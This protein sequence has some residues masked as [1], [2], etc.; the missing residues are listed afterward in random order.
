MTRKANPAPLAG[1]GGANS[2]ERKSDSTTLAR[3]EGHS[4]RR[5]KRRD[6]RAERIEAEAPVEPKKPVVDEE[7][8]ERRVAELKSLSPIKYAVARSPTAKALGIPVAILDKLVKAEQP[9]REGMQGRAIEFAVIDPWPEP[10][11]G[12]VLLAE[13]VAVLLRYVIVTP[14]QAVAVALWIVFTHVHDAFDVSPCLRAK[15][16]HKRSGKTTLFA[17][18]QRLVCKP[19]GAS[20]IT[21][22]ALLR[23]IELHHPTML[24]DEMDALMGRDKE[25]SEALR[26]L[27]NS[28]FSRS[29][30]TFT[31]NVATR[32]NG[33]EPRDF[34]TWT[35]LALAGIG[36]LPDTLRDRSVEIEM[37][38]KLKTEKVE[39]L[40]RRDG[41]DLH[42]LA[43]KIVRWSMDNFD[44]L[45]AAEPEMPEDLNDR[46]AD[47]CE[48][49]VAIADLAGGDWPAQARAAAVA[50]SGDHLT[51]D[52]DVDTLLLG[53]I[54]DAFDHVAADRL[55]SEQLVSLLA[56]LEGRPWGELKSR[57]AHD[58]ISAVEEA[59]EVRNFFGDN[60]HGQG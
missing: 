53:D 8:I 60:S 3:S 19:R 17:V 30:A 27:M 38:R 59:A 7:T 16:A 18:L 40:R 2:R 10:V 48:P 23:V 44:V 33:Y 28:G 42:G 54:R 57:Q 58:Q 4:A 41:A 49:L 31:M 51:K 20:G 22:S 46:A 45:S 24:I 43:R 5:P 36:D 13:L 29:G 35:P 26:G 56:E 55:S 9:Q 32:D 39:R 6:S 34:S 52:D 50:L 37:K 25:M 14:L 1:G 12:R 11:E 21:P 15:S 47:A